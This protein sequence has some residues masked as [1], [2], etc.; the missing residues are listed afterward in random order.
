MKL[1]D[2]T[3]RQTAGVCIYCGSTSYNLANDRPLGEEHVIAESMGGCLALELAACEDCE[4]RINSFEQ[5]IQKTVFHTTRIRMNVR[6]K[7]RKRTGDSLTFMATVGGINLNVE[8]P[9][10]R[11]PS[12]LFLP[13]LGPPGILVGRSPEHA[14]FHGG[15]IC[16][17]IPSDSWRPN[18]PLLEGFSSPVIDTKKFVQF[19]AKI[20][21][22]FAVYA[23]GLHNFEPLL[24]ELIREGNAVGPY[25]FIGGLTE[26]P[27]PAPNLHELGLGVENFKGTD[28]IVARI[29]LFSVLGTPIYSICV[30]KPSYSQNGGP[31]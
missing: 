19:L 31:L 1:S 18:I 16:K 12:L 9:I 7:R 28:Y 15:W 8:L 26:V 17:A 4:R 5:P 21:H 25:H 23:L 29:R 14:H 2:V 27:P 24:L 6:R 30:G 10:D 3:T 20:G 22:C 13:I 11:V